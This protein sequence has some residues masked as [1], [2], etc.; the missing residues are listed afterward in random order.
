MAVDSIGARIAK[1]LQ[2]ARTPQFELL[3]SNIQN[4]VI[5]RVNAE[6]QKIIDGSATDRHELA[7]LRKDGLKLANSLPI[8]AQFRI[9]NLNN[10][11]QLTD[12]ATETSILTAKLGSDDTITQEEVDSFNEYKQTVIDRLNNI[13]LFA[14]PDIRDG[15]AIPNLKESLD[16]LKALTPVVGTRDDNSA[17]F[18]TLS[19]FSSK[20]VTASE[21]TSN[22]I[23]T[24]LDLEQFIQAKALDI[25]AH[26]TEMGEV[27]TA[28]KKEEIEDIKIKFANVLTAI[29]V[30]FEMNEALS[31]SITNGL[32]APRPEP[33]SV[34]NLFY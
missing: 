24:A 33:G 20:I 11:G 29:S 28:R 31:S 19:D 15:N 17:L 32:T 3:F 7:S 26:V 21:T 14:H 34:L 18:S 10:S 16:D 13:Y 5:R 22:T 9:G 4:T 8:I 1:N 30:T 12:L 2:A 23:T 6:S 25:Q 27:E